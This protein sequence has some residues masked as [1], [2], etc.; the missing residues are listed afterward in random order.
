M[1][2]T[3]SECTRYTRVYNN[4]SCKYGSIFIFD[5]YDDM[6]LVDY[7]DKTTEWTSI[8]IIDKEEDV[9]FKN[10]YSKDSKS[11]EGNRCPVCGFSAIP[12]LFSVDCS[13]KNCQ[14]YK[15]RS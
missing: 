10:I 14:N 8:H 4:V 11:Y 3:P 7:D 5:S 13:N 9:I 15:A 12:Y 2:M 1:A 6:V